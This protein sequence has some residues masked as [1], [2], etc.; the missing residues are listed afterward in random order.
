MHSL[1]TQA[2]P[3][4]SKHSNIHTYHIVLLH[5]LPLTFLMLFLLDFT[6]PNVIMHWLRRE[7]RGGEEGNYARNYVEIG[8][9][10][11]ERD[12]ERETDKNREKHKE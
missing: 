5:K 7:G 2:Q 1:V 12:R 8:K 4:N 11:R 3:R 10:W 6:L 9:G